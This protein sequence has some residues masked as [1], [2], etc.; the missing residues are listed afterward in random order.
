MAKPEPSS[1]ISRAG[2]WGAKKWRKLAVVARRCSERAY[3]ER[4]AVSDIVQ[5]IDD[6]P[7][8]QLQAWLR[9]LSWRLRQPDC[10]STPVRVRVVTQWLLGQLF[11]LW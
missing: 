3:P 8:A 2:D 7:N 9:N 4:C 1:K 5:A 10:F 11:R 6:I